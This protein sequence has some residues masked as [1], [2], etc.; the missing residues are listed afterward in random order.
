[1]YEWEHDSFC[2]HATGLDL[3]PWWTGVPGLAPYGIIQWGAKG[4]KQGLRDRGFVAPLAEKPSS[5]DWSS[6]MKV[7]AVVGIGVVGY[8][9]YRS[10][11]GGARTAS[12]AI[13]GGMAGAS[14]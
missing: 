5:F 9:L 2:D 12:S 10:I 8:F 7:G 3:P 6:V 4:I 13:R 1:M 11:R 14:E